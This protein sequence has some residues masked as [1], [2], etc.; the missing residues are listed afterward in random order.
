[1][2]EVRMNTNEL[3]QR[4]RELTIGQRI[5]LSG[6]AYTARDAAHQRIMEA[7]A[8]DAPLP[9]PLQGA[10]IYYTGPAPTP[11]GMAI[12]SAGPTTSSRLDRFTPTLMDHGVIA[13]IGKGQRSP[14]V[15]EAIRRNQ[16]VYLVALGGAAAL[17]AASIIHSEVIAYE[18][19][20]T[21]SVK[22]IE[23]KDFPLIVAIDSKGDVLF[24]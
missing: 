20:G 24:T 5:L 15:I 10:V 4:A 22:K 9:F 8:Q 11:D 12:G 14:E 1:M 7:L 2:S 21:E 17:A 16:G 13:T 18:E 6:T 3:T 23:L 19:L